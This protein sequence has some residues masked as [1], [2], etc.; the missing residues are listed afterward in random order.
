MAHFDSVPTRYQPDFK[1]AL[2]T[3]HRLK[4]AEDEKQHGHKVPLLLGNGK[5]TGVSQIMSTHH[6]DGMTT[7]ST[8]QPVT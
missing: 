1:K 2:S 4:Q 7:D 8:G 3:M 6:K 5:Q